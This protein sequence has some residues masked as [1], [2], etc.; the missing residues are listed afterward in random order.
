MA[1]K[2]IS[3]KLCHLLRYEH[4]PV[5]MDQEGYIVFCHLV[6]KSFRRHTYNS[7]HAAASLSEGKNTG[8]PRFEFKEHSK[9]GLMIR[10]VT[11]EFHRSHSAQRHGSCCELKSMSTSTSVPVSSCATASSSTERPSLPVAASLVLDF[12]KSDVPHVAFLPLSCLVTAEAHPVNC[13]GERLLT[14]SL[15]EQGRQIRQKARLLLDFLHASFVW[16]SGLQDAPNVESLRSFYRNHPVE[17]PFTSVR[18][19]GPSLQAC[20]RHQCLQSLEQLYVS[21]LGVLTYIHSIDLR[22][23]ILKYENGIDDWCAFSVL[24][25]VSNWDFLNEDSPWHPDWFFSWRAIMKLYNEGRN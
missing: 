20:E 24:E 1:N 5:V 3:Q 9:H 22:E 15:V 11:R 25:F 10:A 13:Q 17:M 16:L 2:H 6:E 8:G 21:F 19:S 18:A 7:I 14:E 23:L 4:C 12:G